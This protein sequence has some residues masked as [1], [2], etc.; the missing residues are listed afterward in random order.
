MC[1]QRKAWQSETLFH[2]WVKKWTEGYEVVG[3]FSFLDCKTWRLLRLTVSHA[4]QSITGL[5]LQILIL[6]QRVVFLKT[7]PPSFIEFPSLELLSWEGVWITGQREGVQNW[8][9]W[10][11]TGWDMFLSLPSRYILVDWLVEVA[12]MKDFS[13]LCLH[14]TVGCVDRYL[15]LRP[16]PRY[17]LQLLG[18]A[19]M[20]ICTR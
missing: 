2:D 1:N 4:L 3:F 11:L 16:V 14:M 19:C 13:C 15:K 7:T 6:V 12:T 20:V 5:W 8:F 9:G 17:Q 10:F 18:I